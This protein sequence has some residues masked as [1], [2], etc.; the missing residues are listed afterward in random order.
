M[1]KNRRFV[2]GWERRELE[3][4]GIAV[5]RRVRVQ[6]PVGEP[7]RRHVARGRLLLEVGGPDGSPREVIDDDGDPP[8]ERPALRDG[9]R[10]PGNPEAA[11]S[12]D[13]GQVDVPNVVRALCGERLLHRWT[14]RSGRRFRRRFQ[15]ATHRGR[16][17]MKA[18][19]CQDACDASGSH[20]RAEHLQPLYEVADELR[21]PVHG[22]WHLDERIRSFVIESL[23]PGG[24]RQRRDE[25]VSRGLCLRPG[26]RGTQLQNRESLARRIVRPAL[27]W[28][29]LLAGVLDATLLKKKID[30]P[31]Q[32]VDFRLG[33]DLSVGMVRSAGQCV[34]ECDCRH[35]GAV[36]DG[37]ADVSGPMSGQGKPV[38][39]LRSDHEPS[40]G[41]AVRLQL[42]L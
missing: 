7:N 9:E 6:I 11:D 31:L 30:L 1:S 41:L 4:R 8:T 18:G 10:P 26:P 29:A 37:R 22:L 20:L 39:L 17:E 34:G 28:E 2:G 5:N 16:A 13:G 3:L 12:W 40:G 19:T 38:T 42:S 15:L 14:I 32:V 25:E 36:N 35:R 23:A 27:G 24:D 33:P 21:K